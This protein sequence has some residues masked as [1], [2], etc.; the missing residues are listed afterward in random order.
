MLVTLEKLRAEY[1]PGYGVEW[2]R[3]AAR[4]GVIPAVR[5]G[6]KWL[7]DPV[8]VIARLKAHERERAA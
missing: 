7:F 5:V 6:R 8:E 3:R 4:A 1:L 2:I